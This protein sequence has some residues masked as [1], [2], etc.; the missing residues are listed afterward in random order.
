[1]FGATII[2]HYVSKIKNRGDT[3]RVFPL[4]F[5]WNTA[6]E[7]HDTLVVYWFCAARF[8]EVEYS[9]VML[10]YPEPVQPGDYSVAMSIHYPDRSVF[11]VRCV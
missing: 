1:M 9:Y 7:L 10:R 5:L 2:E 4:F 3:Y 6:K 11:P 8:Y